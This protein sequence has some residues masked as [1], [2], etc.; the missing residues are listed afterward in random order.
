M[1]RRDF[2]L[3][4]AGQPAVL[5]CEQLFMR[6]LDSQMNGT[7]GEL[8]TALALDLKT[9]QA[10]RL[11]DTAWLSREDLKRELDRVLASFTAAGGR[12]VVAVVL[13]ATA[14]L[15][16]GSAAAAANVASNVALEMC[17]QAGSSGTPGT[18]T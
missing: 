16:N 17:S 4:R 12:I 9:A 11:A 18:A 15:L 13:A 14:I 8:F 5:S 3:L 1:N 7:T 10:V 2:L 6:Y